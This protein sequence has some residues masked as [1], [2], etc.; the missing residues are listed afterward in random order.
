ML[1]KLRNG[2]TFLPLK[3]LRYA[4]AALEGHTWF[5]SS[6]YDTHEEGEVQYQKFPSKASKGRV[7]CLKGR[8]THDGSW[9]HYAIAWPQA[10]PYNATLMKGLTFVSYNHYDYENIWHGLSA[11]FPFVGWHLKNGCSRVP[12]RWVLYHWGELRTKMG[13]W[14]TLLL[15]ATFDGPINIEK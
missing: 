7:L 10:L 12:S 2:I 5:M 13:L 9:N 14:L 1:E 4:K 11:V 8:D 6:M 3:D 15:E